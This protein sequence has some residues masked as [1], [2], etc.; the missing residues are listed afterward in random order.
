MADEV[1]LVGAS[2]TRSM[3]GVLAAEAMLCDL[4]AVSAGLPTRV[5]PRRVYSLAEAEA[6]VA[7]GQLPLDLFFGDPDDA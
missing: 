7:D 5:L 4:H 6:H 1:I 2:P 3:W